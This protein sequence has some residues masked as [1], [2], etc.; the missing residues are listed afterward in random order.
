VGISGNF[1]I[2]FGGNGSTGGALSQ[3]FDTTPG[4][5]YKVDYFVTDQQG[6]G[7]DQTFQVEALNGGTLLNSVNGSIPDLPA[8][9]FN[10]LAGPEL[11]FVATGASTTLSS[12]DTSIVPLSNCCNWALDGVTVNGSAVGGV[13]EPST[14]AMMILGFAAVGFM[15]YLRKQNGHALP[16]A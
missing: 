13:P 7:G 15:A 11:S 9:T 14:W 12:I 2:G 1:S 10:W 8:G 6:N 5:Q 3:T 16:L 4:L